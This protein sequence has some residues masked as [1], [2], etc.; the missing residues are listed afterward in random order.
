MNKSFSIEKILIELKHLDVLYKKIMQNKHYHDTNLEK[1]DLKNIRMS[2]K[3]REFYLNH[4]EIKKK[5]QN[6]LKLNIMK[7]ESL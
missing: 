6:C 3:G 7:N 2:E 5:F 1:M 4:M